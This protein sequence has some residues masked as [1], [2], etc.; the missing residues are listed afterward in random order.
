[1][2][3]VVGEPSTVEV[4]LLDGVVV[5]CSTGVVVDVA[6]GLGAVVVV[7]AGRAVVVV[8]DGTGTAGT[9]CTAGSGSGRT[10]T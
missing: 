7:V 8:V 10:S 4:V 1:M 6:P 5:V 3:E 2:V 9:Y